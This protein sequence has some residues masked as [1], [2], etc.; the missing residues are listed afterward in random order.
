V[1]SPSKLDPLSLHVAMTA[2]EIIDGPD[3]IMIPKEPPPGEPPYE[4]GE[5]LAI[6]SADGVT[7]TG[8]IVQIDRHRIGVE[9]D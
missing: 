8:T 4:V 3:I 2:R 7:Y 9:L 6:K 5:G 1:T